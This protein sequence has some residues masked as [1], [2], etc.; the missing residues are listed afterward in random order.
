MELSSPFGV[1]IL[2]HLAGPIYSAPSGEI[3]SLCCCTPGH[4][5]SR[6]SSFSFPIFTTLFF[7]R[8]FKNVHLTSAFS[9]VTTNYPPQAFF[10]LF[11]FLI[12]IISFH[13][14][15]LFHH[16]LRGYAQTWKENHCHL[17]WAVISCCCKSEH[18]PKKSGGWKRG[19]FRSIYFLH[20]SVT[21]GSQFFLTFASTNS[22][23]IQI[24]T[25][26]RRMP[27]LLKS[28]V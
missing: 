22:H 5:H 24:A 20:A 9:Y 3:V 7:T 21:N 28:R 6:F 14:H 19:D 26:Q 25:D 27:M 17:T 23:R 4:P 2:L 18:R 8:L 12:F 11:L 13:N 10:F 1:R 15:R 16:P